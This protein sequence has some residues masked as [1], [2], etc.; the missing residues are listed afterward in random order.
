MPLNPDAPTFVFSEL[1][2][3]ILQRLEHARW[4][5]QKRLAGWKYAP[6]RNNK[7][8]FHPCLV[9]FDD[10]TADEKLKDRQSIQNIPHLLKMV[11][12]MIATDTN[13]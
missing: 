6:I 8:L 11:N 4:C 9:D 2:L 12:L 1:E 7:Q 13:A 3:N 10:L 5:A